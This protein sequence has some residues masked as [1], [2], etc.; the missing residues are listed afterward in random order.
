MIKEF[1]EFAL[2]GNMLDMAIGIVLG[3]AFGTIISSL[4]ADVLM[5]IV[6]S[7]LQAPDFSNLF[8]VLK[9]PNDATGVSMTSL[10]SI[11]EAGG[12]VLA[13]GSF[14]NSLISFLIVAMALF[15][16]VKNMNK[17][18]KKEEE[19]PPAPKGPTQEELLTD[20]RDLLKAK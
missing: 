17:L 15:V 13:Y 12:V 5:P 2:K 19:A 11:R 10:D 18:K 4:V 14:I 1:K 3:A 9:S 8:V 16:V 6:S 20:I 7:I